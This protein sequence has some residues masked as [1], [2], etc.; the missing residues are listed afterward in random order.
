MCDNDEQK[1]TEATPIS[2]QIQKE[3]LKQPEYRRRIAEGIYETILQAYEKME[4]MR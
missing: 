2:V 1:P 3:F 4:Y